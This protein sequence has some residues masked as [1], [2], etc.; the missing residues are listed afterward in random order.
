MKS[1]P[2]GISIISTAAGAGIFR[3]EVWPIDVA[4]T[5]LVPGLFLV[6]HGL[7][8]ELQILLRL[9][10]RERMTVARC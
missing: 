8:F 2:F 5:L 4:R 7:R 10:D 6:G 9:H 1:Q 3:V